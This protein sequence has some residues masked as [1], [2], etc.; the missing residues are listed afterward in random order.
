MYICPHILV[1]G[2]KTIFDRWCY[3]YYK[4]AG[5]Q[6]TNIRGERECVCERE[7]TAAISKWGGESWRECL[8]GIYYNIIQAYTYTHIN[9]FLLPY[10]GSSRGGGFF[11]PLQKQ[12]QSCSLKASFPVIFSG[13]IVTFSIHTRRIRTRKT[14]LGCC[15]CTHTHIYKYVRG[16]VRIP[17]ITILL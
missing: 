10:L 4:L 1:V 13:N 6:F 15:W 12:Q 11:E 14:T 8:G 16:G 5:L 2:A 3:Y 9:S 17:N 7:R